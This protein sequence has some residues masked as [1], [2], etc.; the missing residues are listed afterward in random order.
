MK[1]AIMQPYFMPYIGYFQLAN[2]VDKFI[3]YDNIQYSKKGWINRNRILLNDKE[4]IMTIPLRKASDYL[5]V[6]DRE[7]SGTWTKERSKLLNQISN[8]YSKAPEFKNVFSVVEGIVCHEDTN[9]FGFIHNSLKQLFKYMK[10][11]TPIV[12]SSSINV[13]TG[14]KGKDR[15]IGL[16]LAMGAREYINP[17]GGM[18]LYNKEEFLESG[19]KLSFHRIGAVKY[20]QQ[21]AEFIPHLSILDVLMYN[22]AEA[23]DDFLNNGFNII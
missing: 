23:I 10:I 9:L 13:D 20:K 22:S 11:E 12:V 17:V 16:C 6:V 4:T 19:V 21:R 7:L 15:V 2:A 14:L 5:D 8:S 18:E 1:V 3:V